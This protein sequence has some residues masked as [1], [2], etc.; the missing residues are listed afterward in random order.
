MPAGTIVI[1]VPRP[2][3]DVFAFVGDLETA[4]QWVP[5]LVSMRKVTE[6]SIGVGTRYVEMV[7][8]GKQ[9]EEAQL[10][11]TQIEPPRLFA[12][13]GE[14]GPSRFQVR[15][16]LESDEGGTKL[17]HD[18]TMQMTG[19]FWIMTPFVHGWVKKNSRAGLDNLRKLLTSEAES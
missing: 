2:I 12:F 15:Y 13:E 17:T 4:P 1:H 9:Q 14:G 16:V 3:E 8:M 11:V 6:G 7:Q 10:R 18:Y 19:C 5:D